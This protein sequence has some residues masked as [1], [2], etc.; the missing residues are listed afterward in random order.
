M[1]IMI[2]WLKKNGKCRCWTNGDIAEH[3]VMGM[4]SFRDSINRVAKE[5]KVSFD[6]AWNMVLKRD[7]S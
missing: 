1:K 5:K 4:T 7:W 6:E 2:V 3:L